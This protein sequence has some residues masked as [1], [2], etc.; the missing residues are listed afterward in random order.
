ME[1]IQSI[2]PGTKRIDHQGPENHLELAEWEKA[3]GSAVSLP[4]TAG[5]L[6]WDPGAAAT[7]LPTGSTHKGV[8]CTP[9][10]SCHHRKDP[11]PG[12]QET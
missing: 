7:S 2:H 12:K 4:P 5:Y 9:V 10:S 6:H 3:G 8:A 11:D 1:S